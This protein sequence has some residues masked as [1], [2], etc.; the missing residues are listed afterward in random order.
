MRQDIHVSHCL[1]ASDRALPVPLSLLACFCVQW[2]KYIHSAFL[3]TTIDYV[4]LGVIAGCNC[5]PFIGFSYLLDRRRDCHVALRPLLASRSMGK[6]GIKVRVIGDPTDPIYIA[7]RQFL[8]TIGHL[9]PDLIT[10]SQGNP[11]MPGG[12]REPRC[13]TVFIMENL[14]RRDAMFGPGANAKKAFDNR[15][16]LFIWSGSKET[17]GIIPFTDDDIG[18]R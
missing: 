7:L 10:D 5:A 3:H 14:A 8:T 6:D 17:P 11:H 18:Q 12:R 15:F 16:S 9:A 1:H 4:F 13:V 2:D